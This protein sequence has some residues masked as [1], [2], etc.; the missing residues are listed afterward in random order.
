MQ[1]I[2]IGTNIIGILGSIFHRC[3]GISPC[4]AAKRAPAPDPLTESHTQHRG[5]LEVPKG[6]LKSSPMPSTPITAIEPL[7]FEPSPMTVSSGNDMTVEE[8]SSSASTDRTKITLR[9]GDSIIEYVK[10]SADEFQRMP[11]SK[12]YDTSVEEFA[13]SIADISKFL[14]T[15]S[16][17]T[18]WLATPACLHEVPLVKIMAD[19]ARRVAGPAHKHSIAGLKDLEKRLGHTTQATLTLDIA[20][21]NFMNLFRR[22]CLQLETCDDYV[23]DWMRRPGLPT[24][25]L[26]EEHFRKMVPLSKILAKQFGLQALPEDDDSLK[27]LVVEALPKQ[28]RR[29]IQKKLRDRC[30]TVGDISYDAVSLQTLKELS[31]VVEDKLGFAER[32]RSPYSARRANALIRSPHFEGGEEDVPEDFS[33]DASADLMYSAYNRA[34]ST[35]YPPQRSAPNRVARSFGRSTTSRDRSSTSRGRSLRRRPSPNPVRAHSIVTFDPTKADS[36]ANCGHTGHTARTCTQ[37]RDDERIKRNIKSFVEHKAKAV[38]QGTSTAVLKSMQTSMA[39]AM[40]R[41]QCESDSLDEEHCIECETDT[42][43][44]DPEDSTASEGGDEVEEESNRTDSE[45]S[46]RK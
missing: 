20:L 42:D 37:P 3:M 29:G 41:E 34:S 24:F 17:M 9:D 4:H 13:D 18:K 46:H 25:K 35:R 32:R 40:Y 7:E 15:D 44:T 39:A 11:Q 45:R 19:I 2:N 5:V 28:V 12:A 6:I 21:E 33:D 23:A 36:C 22:E 8:Q 10:R 43:A 14:T 27:R 16:R 38:A 1:V 26:T 30:Q 31:H